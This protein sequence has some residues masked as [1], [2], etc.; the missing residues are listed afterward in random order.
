MRDF[1]ENIPNVSHPMVLQSNPNPH[2][3]E[4]TA[5]QYSQIIINSFRKKKKTSNNIDD[6]KMTLER[7][8]ENI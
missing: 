4:T 1:E 2:C 6:E 5:K 3:T 8:L 7:L